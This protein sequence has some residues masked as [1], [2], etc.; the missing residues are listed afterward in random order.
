MFHRFFNFLRQS[1]LTILLLL[2]LG[3][4][5]ACGWFVYQGHTRALPPSRPFLPYMIPSARALITPPTIPCHSAT[6]MRSS[7]PRTSTL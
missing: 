2:L 5:A 3:L 1:L 6:S 4:M 7:A